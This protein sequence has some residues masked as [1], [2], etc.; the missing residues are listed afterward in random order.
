ML[1]T[2][3][4]WIDRLEAIANEM[5]AQESSIHLSGLSD[6]IDSI[7]DDLN[8]HQ[9]EIIGDT[10]IIEMRGKSCAAQSAEGR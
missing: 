6:H 1:D 10:P 9:R 7:C 2:L 3:T 4:S 5:E 8:F